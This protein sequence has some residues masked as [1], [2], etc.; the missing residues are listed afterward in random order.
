LLELVKLNSKGMQTSTVPYKPVIDNREIKDSAE[1][2][3]AGFL[4]SLCRKVG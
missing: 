3:N 1:M 2:A 4:A